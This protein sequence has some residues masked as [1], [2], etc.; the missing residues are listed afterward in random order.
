[1]TSMYEALAVPTTPV[2]ATEATVGANAQAAA[3]AGHASTHTG[4]VLAS[5]AH[6]VSCYNLRLRPGW[7]NYAAT[8]ADADP[9]SAIGTSGLSREVIV[10]VAS[11]LVPVVV[12]IEHEATVSGIEKPIVPAAVADAVAAV[13]I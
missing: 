7:Q 9:A 6:P 12:A 11:H 8:A 1:M 2:G 4:A 5:G 10:L 13:A 3:R